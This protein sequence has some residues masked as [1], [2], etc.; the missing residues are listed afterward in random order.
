MPARPV[1][2]A[3]PAPLEDWPLNRKLEEVRQ[4]LA[5]DLLA[6]AESEACID[7]PIEGE[8]SA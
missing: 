6:A 8:V 5:E 7:Q 2:A 1:A 4:T 3:N